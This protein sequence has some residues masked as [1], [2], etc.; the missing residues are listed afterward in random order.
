[1]VSIC[2]KPNRAGVDDFQIRINAAEFHDLEERLR[3]PISIPSNIHFHRNIIEQFIDAFKQQVALNP[4]YQ[5]DRVADKCFA[6]MLVEPNIKIHKQCADVDV[7]DRPLTDDQCCT[8][9]YCRPMWCADCL[10]RW[11]AAKQNDFDRESWLEQ[12][13]T[14]PMC[15]A[16]FCMLDVSYIVRPDEGT[17]AAT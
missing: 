8:N 11:F 9:C 17:T 5:A 12:K 2:V 4:I 15:R 3:R 7:Y 16:K 10:A 1:M 6:C 13:C 14:C